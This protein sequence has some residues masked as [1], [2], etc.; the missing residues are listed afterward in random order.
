MLPGTFPD[1]FSNEEFYGIMS[2]EDD[3]ENIDKVHTRPVYYTLQEKFP[4]TGRSFMQVSRPAAPLNVTASVSGSDVNLTWDV[5][6]GDIAGYNVYRSEKSGNGFVRLNSAVVSAV[7]YLDRGLEQKTYY[8]LITAVTTGHIPL[9][10]IPSDEKIVNVGTNTAPVAS[11]LS[12]TT[13]EDTAFSITL[14]ATDPEGDSLTYEIVAQP[15]SG[16]LS[17]ISG[18]KVTYTPNSN[19]NGADSFTYKANDGHQ[20]SNAATVTITV[21]PVND[22]P[23]ISGMPNQQ[24]LEDV[25]WTLDVSTYISDIDTPKE[26]LI[27]AE[28]SAYATVNGQVITFLYPNGITQEQVTITVSYVELSASQTIKV[29]VMPVNDPPAVSGIPDQTIQQEQSFRSFDLDDYVK[30][31]DNP[32]EQLTWVYSGNNK[33]SVNID[34]STH[35]VT[36]T[37][38]ASPWT[39]E[40]TITFTA[41]DPDGLSASDTAIFKVK[42]INHAPAISG[43][44]D[45]TLNED[46]S[47]D[48]TIDLLQYAS[49]IDADETL[50]FTI[51][52]NTAADSGVSIDSN[53]YIDIS[54]TANWSGAS[55]VTIRV[56]DSGGL[57]AED[58]FTVTVNPVNDPPVIQGIPDQQ[59]TEDI[60]WTLDVSTYINDIDT[61]KESLIITEGSAYATVNGQVITFLYPN[62]VTQE[63]VTI[64]VSDG[65]LSASQTIG[66]TIT[67]V[68]DE[69]KAII[70][71]KVKNKDGLGIEGVTLSL[72]NRH[73]LFSSISTDS[74]GNYRFDGVAPGCIYSFAAYP[75]AGTNYA[76]TAI[77]K[78]IP[79]AGTYVDNDITLDEGGIAISGRVTDEL[80]GQQ[81]S[82]LKIK[83]EQKDTNA[84]IDTQT[85]ASGEYAFANLAKGQAVILALPERVYAGDSKI[86]D[87]QTDAVNVDFVLKDTAVIRGKA[88][89][90]DTGEPFTNAIVKTFN[91]AGFLG[92][93]SLTDAKGEFNMESLVTGICSLKLMPD[94]TTA[95]AWSLP[96]PCDNI[97]LQPRQ[98]VT[99]LSIN[100]KPGALVTAR[101]VDS[102][103]NPV[104]AIEYRV[105]EKDSEGWGLSDEQ[106]RFQIRLPQG[107]NILNFVD[108]P[109]YG[110]LGRIIDVSDASQVIDLG[111]IIVYSNQDGAKISGEVLNG[112]SYNKIGDFYITAYQAGFSI[113]EDTI[114]GI[115]NAA[116]FKQLKIEGVYE[117]G[118]LS[119]SS[120]YDL[121]LSVYK[122]LDD[123]RYS[124]TLRDKR[125]N[126]PAGSEDIDLNY[127][128]EGGIISGKIIDLDENPVLGA[129]SVLADKA[130]GNYQGIA[131]TDQNGDYIF[132]NVPE[133]EYAIKGLHSLY[134]T[135]TVVCVDVSDDKT[136]TAEN[137]VISK[138]FFAP[139][140]APAIK[141]ISTDEDVLVS[142]DLTQNETD[143]IDSDAQL[144]W[145]ISGVN[146]DLFTADIDA[147]SDV[148]T[149][150][151]VSNANGSDVVTLTLT[152]SHGL[153][154]TQDIT[155]TI[156]PV[157]DPPVFGQ[158]PDEV[159]DEGEQ[160]SFTVTAQDIDG[161]SLVYSAQNLP[162]GAVFRPI[163]DFN[164]NQVG[165]NFILR[166]S[167]SQGRS[168]PYIVTFSVADG[169][170][171]IS[172]DVRITVNDVPQPDLPPT[173]QIISITPSPVEL[174]GAV[175]FAGAG[176]DEN[177]SIVQYK[178]VSD[179]GGE[180]Y[181]STSAIFTT[182][183]LSAGLHTISL[184]VKSSADIWSESVSASL[185]V[186]AEP[187]VITYPQ[188]GA[189]LTGIVPVSATA[190]LST[191]ENAYLLVDENSVAGDNTRPFV[192]DLNTANYGNGN[193]ALKVKA[194]YTYYET[195]KLFGLIPITVAKTRWVQSAAVNVVFDNPVPDLRI[196]SPQDG[197]V[198]SGTVSIDAIADGAAFV[199]YYIDN[200]W[201]AVD[202]SPFSYT[203]DTTRA[204]NGEHT[205]YIKAFYLSGLRWIT[206]SV[207]KVEV[208][209]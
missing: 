21:T 55:D 53:R 174:G 153:T 115:K 160:L 52:N 81:I 206:S 176:I 170:V 23:T 117:L 140:I 36:L 173:A 192:F 25:A 191:I 136:T 187:I 150:T 200:K 204:A 91:A 62:G 167:Y 8:Y 141:D 75:P 175:T 203:W 111:D 134:V 119:P 127:N 65:E 13:D 19:Y 126:I 48:N 49:D 131:T 6:S 27:I 33:I 84:Q 69:E 16:G 172:M 78:N 146:T 120:N 114:Y 179:I 76:L 181:N 109:T 106:G 12:V 165:G 77:D 35:I 132:Y 31:I 63:Q 116:A 29:D 7:S 124:I 130:T 30:D 1:N 209:N 103:G 10:G 133:G 26:S 137:I 104:Y 183:V 194:S 96:A 108:Y 85:S 205:I 47:L 74:Q 196:V 14:N 161:D 18:N 39:G 105:N 207:V 99:D 113:G 79:V 198:L 100:S 102:L 97:Y 145:S 45:K 202:F 144:V 190:N 129:I 67:P 88:V 188:A 159:I 118:A 46:T 3:G 44:P 28:G 37:Y 93:E 197:A 158:T 123:G 87:F 195:Y 184:T 70:I 38:P 186:V 125:L 15:N 142:Y 95:Y 57:Y 58:T 83:Y 42:P 162:E 73:K 148:L 40:E 182:S 54:P 50:T 201:T 20:D 90:E 156:N 152:N 171:S 107:K 154:D 2:I 208:E 22:A 56:T 60:S 163:V 147:A 157:N 59:G 138:S 101:V 189:Q 149:I 168:E 151:P 199:F 32:D 72:T 177:N 64:T 89:K 41:T 92:A 80:A 17:V 155:V 71:G 169:T 185:E 112:S 178:W 24:G 82:N 51:T 43:L 86:M 139:E 193:H 11:D 135:S 5:V 98:A 122:L 166:P 68:D 34:A 94:S 110:C 164:G 128:Q 180:I 4:R 9:E 61:P 143:P 121:Y 66:V